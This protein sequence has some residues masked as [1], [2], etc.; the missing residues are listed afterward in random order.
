MYKI[1]PPPRR[2]KESKTQRRG[3]EGNK[4]GK[5]K[6]KEKKGGG[7]E[8]GEV[9]NER[10]KVKEKGISGRKGRLGRGKVGRGMHHKKRVK[11]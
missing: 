2:G 9:K 7:R 3:R 6:G 11:P 4:K 1:L 10:K 5:E 8:K